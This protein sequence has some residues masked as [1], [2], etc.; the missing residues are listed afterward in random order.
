MIIGQV[1]DKG[2]VKVKA[3]SGKFDLSF[4]E[5]LE[6]QEALFH[7]LICPDHACADLAGLGLNVVVQLIKEIQVGDCIVHP[8]FR[9]LPDLLGIRLVPLRRG[10]LSM[11][12]LMG[13][14]IILS[15][16]LSI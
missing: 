2:F 4:P 11:M 1:I 5:L 14:N 6:C 13:R 9:Q 10:R 15:I 3:Q 16:F 7:Y 8:C 12:G